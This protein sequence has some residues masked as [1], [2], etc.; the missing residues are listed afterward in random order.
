MKCRLYRPYPFKAQTF[1]KTNA[2]RS[3]FQLLCDSD[4]HK[5]LSRAVLGQ[6][7]GEKIKAKY[8]H[9]LE[10]VKLLSN[11]TPD[12]WTFL[13]PYCVPPVPTFC[14]TYRPSTSTSTS[15][16]LHQIQQPQLYLSYLK[17]SS[18]TQVLKRDVN[19]AEDT[20]KTFKMASSLGSFRLGLWLLWKDFIERHSCGV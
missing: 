7:R 14:C 8:C 6:H 3:L 4:W 1:P 15:S 12:Y 20:V 13:A 11:W 19:K 10:D 5:S 17:T 16:S 9:G 18:L 2:E